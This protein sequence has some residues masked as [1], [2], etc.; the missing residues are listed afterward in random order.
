MNI[1]AAALTLLGDR[2][3]NQDRVATLGN[4]DALLLIVVDGMGGHSQGA[5][6][7]QATEEVLRSLFAEAKKPIVDPQGFLTMALS[8][9]HDEVVR[10]G[11]GVALDNRPRATCAIC[12]VQDDSAYWAHVGDSR[13]Y[14]LRDGAVLERTRDHSHVELLLR[15]GVIEEGQMADHPMRN[16][17]E[18]CLGGDSPLP[19]VAVTSRRRLQ[20]G[21]AVLLCTDGLWSG[22]TDEHIAALATDDDV[23]MAS[24]LEE[25]GNSAVRANAPHSDNTSACGVR[26]LGPA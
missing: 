23:A 1:D 22:V 26:W 18:C 8:Y 5:T 14:Q 3:E 17:V 4:G 12:I 6:A 13:I 10:L 16:L 20:A 2:K 19:D 25:L 11:E 24:V 21:D 7:A 15:E 9:A